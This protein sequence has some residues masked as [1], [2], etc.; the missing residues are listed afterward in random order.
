MKL[1]EGDKL[2]GQYLMSR[3][4]NLTYGPTTV[5][6]FLTHAGPV[7]I[8]GHADLNFAMIQVPPGS[9]VRVVR[10]G[11]V[12]I[13]EGIFRIDYDVTVITEAGRRAA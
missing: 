5:H 4:A 10:G 11:K 2:I 1:E 12:K 3:T 6:Y 9:D 8:Y 7:F 13:A